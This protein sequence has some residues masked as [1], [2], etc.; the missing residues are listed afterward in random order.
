MP[1]APRKTTEAILADTRR[2][3]LAA[4]KHAAKL[5]AAEKGRKAKLFP[6]GVEAYLTQL[7]SAAK[8][9]EK[10]V[11]GQSVKAKGLEAATLTEEQARAALFTSLVAIRDDVALTPRVASPVAAAFGKGSRIKSDSTPS[12]LGVANAML[13]AYADPMHRKVAAAAGVTP[14]R[15]KTCTQARDALAAADA[16]QGATLTSRKGATSSMHAA[17]A[18]LEKDVAH[19][20][21]VAKHVFRG[22]AIS[23]ADFAST[24]PKHAV[25]KRAPKAAA[26]GAA[27]APASAKS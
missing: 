14:A 19:V 3:L 24:T 17:F 20:R 4:K 5:K 12:L 27:S 6:G 1:T 9:A 15:I 2:V 25:K 26:A 23:L 10:A 7:A 22:D 21:G 18:S 8:A 16:T 11:G 13:E